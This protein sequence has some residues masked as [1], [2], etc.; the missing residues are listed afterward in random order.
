ML[1]DCEDDVVSGVDFADADLF[2]DWAEEGEEAE[3][4]KM[5]R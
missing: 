1:I 2:A 4:V 3:E 5:C